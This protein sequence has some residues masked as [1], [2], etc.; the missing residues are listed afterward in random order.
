MNQFSDQ[1]G[2]PLITSSPYNKFWAEIVLEGKEFEIRNN[3]HITD[4]R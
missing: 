1:S 4:F 2:G 3:K